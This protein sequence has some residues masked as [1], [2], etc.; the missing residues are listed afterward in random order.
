[1]FMRESG[2]PEEGMW[3]GFFDPPT[4]LEELLLLDTDGDVVDLCAGYGTF[5]LPAARLTGRRVLAV[6]CNEGMAEVAARR[7]REQ[8][9]EQVEVLVRDIIE[10]GSGLPDGSAGY[11]MLFNIL[12]GEHPD[13][14]LGEA[15]RLLAPGGLLAVT[16]WVS[17]RPTPRGPSLE[18]RPTPEQCRSWAAAAGFDLVKGPVDLP[19]HH[20]GL[21][22]R[23]QAHAAANANSAA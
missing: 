22:F 9:A 18:I 5:S 16:H 19:P 11:V 4:V 15:R 13:I 12:H 6:D 20:F 14:L 17:D 21:V 3:E 8:G 7:V 1:M 2:M 10:S 23:P